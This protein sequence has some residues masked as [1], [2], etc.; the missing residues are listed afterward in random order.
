MNKESR[1]KKKYAKPKAKKGSF[2]PQMKKCQKF[3][4]V[5]GTC[6]QVYGACSG[7]AI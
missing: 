1:Q 6:G 2:R 4:R 7:G 5:I 3:N